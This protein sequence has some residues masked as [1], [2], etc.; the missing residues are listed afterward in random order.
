M[1]AMGR[2]FFFFLFLFL[3]YRSDA[4]AGNQNFCIQCQ[5][6]GTYRCTFETQSHLGPKPGRFF[7]STYLSEAFKDQCQA[8]S[9]SFFKCGFKPRVVVQAG[10][11]SAQEW[12]V[13]KLTHFR[14]LLY[15]VAKGTVNLIELTASSGQKASNAM[16]PALSK[17]GKI[18]ENP[19][20]K[21]KEASQKLMHR[22]ER[23]FEKAS[24][25]VQS[26]KEQATDKLHQAQRS[27]KEQL[28]QVKEN[29]QDR[30]DTVKEK[31]SNLR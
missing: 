17:A 15:I 11:F 5:Q 2:F 8:Q 3:V 22:G 6:K 16:D 28:N 24:D 20:N 1:G 29:A 14:S 30:I 9:Y 4:W 21:A 26:A 25:K 10:T 23:A 18:F 12:E 7:C 27:A 31:A 19:L 13:L